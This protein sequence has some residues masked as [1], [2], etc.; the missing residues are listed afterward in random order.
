[1]TVNFKSVFFITIVA[2]M[3]QFA[4]LYAADLTPEEIVIGFYTAI[5]K[6]EY[7]KAYE[8]ISQK[9]KDGKKCREWA[10]DWQKT[11]D[12]GQV[13]LV[14][15]S[16]E[17]AKIE[18]DKAIVRSW[19]KSSDIFNKDGIVEHET[20]YLVKEDGVWKLDATEVDL[21]DF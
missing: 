9:M 6:G 7:E 4:S 19:N 13:V 11:V 12:F 18:G 16:V 8:F 20:D 1:M 15:F 3:L 17:S 2:F 5:Q 10:S 21:P 14:D